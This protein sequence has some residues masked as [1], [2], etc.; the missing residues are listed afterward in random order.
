MTVFTTTRPTVSY[1][2]KYKSAENLEWLKPLILNHEIYIPSVAQLN[3]PTDCRPKIAPMSKEEMVT[4]L[5]ND[6][7]RRNPVVALDLL[8]KHESTIRMSIKLHGLDWFMRETSKILNAQMEQFR[9]YSL[10]K[11]FNNL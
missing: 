11:R 8:E 6:Y 5:R 4:F 3:D 7:I 9:V 2:Y 10:S 1:L